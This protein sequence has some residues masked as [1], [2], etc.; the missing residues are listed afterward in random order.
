MVSK[1]LEQRVFQSRGEVSQQLAG[2][3]GSLPKHLDH[4]KPVVISG[5]STYCTALLGFG[6]FGADYF[7]EVLQS[8]S[9][10]SALQHNICCYTRHF[11]WW[12]RAGK[13]SC[14]TYMPYTPHTSQALWTLRLRIGV[15]REIPRF[16]LLPLDLAKPGPLRKVGRA[17]QPTA[18]PPLKNCG[19]SSDE[20]LRQVQPAAEPT[21]RDE[22][23]G[24]AGN[25]GLG[26]KKRG[27]MHRLFSFCV[28]VA[29]FTW[30]R[31]SPA[32]RR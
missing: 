10:G 12:S 28:M 11:D 25:S 26:A 6:Y 30:P 29:W 18:G 9:L 17:G 23:F 20:S 21:R 19:N 16:A 3:P 8:E 27:D 22:P 14:S 24:L 1:R 4:G 7:D 31:L 32:K 2:R 5:S 15:A 13:A